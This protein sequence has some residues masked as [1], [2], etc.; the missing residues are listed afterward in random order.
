MGLLRGL[1]TIL[2]VKHLG[3]Y[4]VHGKL[5]LPVDTFHNSTLT[6][7]LRSSPLNIICR[8]YSSSS[9]RLFHARLVPQLES[10]IL[11]THTP[12]LSTPLRGSC[13]TQ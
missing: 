10:F 12:F 6:S 9:P 8:R 7:P 5:S 1:N 3:Q 2:Y 4:L 13:I 11:L